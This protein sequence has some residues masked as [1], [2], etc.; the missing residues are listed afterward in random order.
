MRDARNDMHARPS[1]AAARGRT[2]LSIGTN[3]MTRGFRI[4]P[5][6][7]AASRMT[8][9]GWF[10]S[11]VEMRGSAVALQQ[12]E[13][14]LSYI[15][16]NDRVNRLVYWLAAQGLTRGD[17]IGVL[18]ENR[19]EYV[20]V[21]LAAAKLGVVT[22]CQNWRQADRE[23]TYCI[24]AV[25]PKLIVVSE[26]YAPTLGRIDHGVARILTFGEEYERALSHANVSSEPPHLAEP[27]DGL[28]ILYTSG[29]T[30]MPKGAVIS[31][32]AM[33]ARTLIGSLDRPLAREDSYL[34]WTPM[35]HMGSTDY[36]YSTLL[37]GGK[38][39]ILDGFQAEAMSHIVATEPLGWLHLNSAVIDRVI[40]QI[41]RDGVRPKGVKF[42]GV[43]P[44]LV[45][46]PQIA[47][48][49][50][51]MGAPFANTFGSTET[52]PVPASKGVIDI[53]VA[54]ERLSKVQSSLCELRLVDENDRDVSDGEPG[55]VL[56]RAPSLFS[57]YWQA[58]D[59]N[60][61]VFRDGWYRMGDVFRRNRDGT[62]DFVDR[63]KYLIKSGGENIYPAEIEGILLA[64]ARVANA[65]V[66]RRVDAKW[67]EVPVVF[68][69][70]RDQQLTADE[71]VA[72][73]R[74]Q[75]AGYKVP[76]DVIFVA[77]EELPRSTS[78][79]IKR[80]EL[81]SRLVATAKS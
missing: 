33:V 26:R 23:L 1:I 29:T 71:V 31:H 56:V 57:G 52:G 42:V 9:A 66:V 14:T 75:V 30:G 28:I 10:R 60:A 25:E 6:A 15:E 17:R 68:V 11:Q 39:I 43:M 50:T 73:C 37:R 40:A 74:D 41:Q 61:E 54:P 45:P 18:S 5:A 51:L 38:V 81:E 36:V 19:Y 32:R 7:I 27:E 34:A 59:V 12:G 22:A 16:L 55:E 78:G 76:K 3:M 2:F 8:I 49:T 63:R 79:K 4:E 47:A 58:P 21:E 48:L 64:S 46:R 44:D 72:M 62:L 80:H 69:V 67:G 77:D 20:E 35:F 24:R 53:G 65:V 70:R 13:R